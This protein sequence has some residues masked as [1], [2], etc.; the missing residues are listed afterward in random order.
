M[1]PQHAAETKG[2]IV[3]MMAAVVFMLGTFQTDGRI[4]VCSHFEGQEKL[5]HFKKGEKLKWTNELALDTHCAPPC[6]QC[7][8]S[9]FCH[10]FYFNV[11]LG[12]IMFSLCL[13]LES[14]N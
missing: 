11:S 4:I 10:T 1:C 12:R 7:S 9:M 13:L 14:E 8:P 5:L 3:A 6:S 2:I